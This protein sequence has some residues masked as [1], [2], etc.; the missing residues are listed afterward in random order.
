[1]S[2][3]HYH[4][5]TGRELVTCPPTGPASYWNPQTIRELERKSIAD[6][7]CTNRHLLTG[8]VL[9]FG[10]GKPGT[11]RTPQPYRGMV[12]GE[13]TP[14]DIGDAYP[15]GPFDAVLCTQVLQYLGIS[16]SHLA[17]L[18]WFEQWLKPQGHLVMTGPTNWEEVEESDF[19]RF[20]R[21]GIRKLL[22]LSGFEVLTLESRA[23]IDL[24]GAKFSLGWGVVG[25]KKS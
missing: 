1:M 5:G 7:V 25:R 14:F 18:G 21:S 23:E 4:P 13:Y 8:H 10:A 2:L 3:T 19:F 6:F 24:G 9:D 17:V 11:C 20:T 22:E 16:H 15:P 12:A